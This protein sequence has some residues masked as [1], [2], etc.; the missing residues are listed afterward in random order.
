MY[1][2]GTPQSSNPLI[3]GRPAVW[4]AQNVTLHL[5]CINKKVVFSYTL[6][7]KFLILQIFLSL[8]SII[9]LDLFHL[10]PP[11]NCKTSFVCIQID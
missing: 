7:K 10:L 6:Q 8:I 9:F 3:S 11:F 4:D 5:T 2:V 1:N